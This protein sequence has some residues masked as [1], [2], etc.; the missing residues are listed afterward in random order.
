MQKSGNESIKKEKFYL[1][2]KIK[3]THLHTDIS[4]FNICEFENLTSNRTRKHT[5]M[6]LQKSLAWQPRK[7]HGWLFIS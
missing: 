7:R 2:I 4:A 3:R 1:F 5:N 6:H